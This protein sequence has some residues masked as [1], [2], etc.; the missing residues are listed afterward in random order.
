MLQRPE[1]CSGK[2]ST[3]GESPGL[4]EMRR[5]AGRGVTKCVGARRLMTAAELQAADAALWRPHGSAQ[6]GHRSVF[7]DTFQ[8]EAYQDTNTAAPG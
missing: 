5:S 4:A 3:R 8:I 2:G 6:W 7:N 1:G